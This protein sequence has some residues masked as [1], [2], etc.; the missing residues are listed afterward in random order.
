MSNYPPGAAND[1]NAPYNELLT[2]TIKV[3]VS[4]ELGTFVDVDVPLDEEG[5]PETDCLNEAVQIAIKD[6]YN[7]DNI[8]TVLNRINIWDWR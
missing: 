5:Y 2:K 7:V 8:D 6:K 4:A 3:E 1:P